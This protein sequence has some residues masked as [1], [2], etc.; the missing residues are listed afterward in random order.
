MTAIDAASAAFDRNS[1]QYQRLADCNATTIV[2]TCVC[3][4]DCPNFF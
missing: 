1:P 3:N 2:T 4:N